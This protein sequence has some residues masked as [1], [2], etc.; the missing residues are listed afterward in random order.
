MS[1]PRMSF[2]KDSIPLIQ[3]T[4]LKWSHVMNLKQHFLNKLRAK[5][6]MM[7]GFLEGN[8]AGTLVLI[9]CPLVFCG[10]SVSWNP[11]STLV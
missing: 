9:W 6:W 10:G 2:G 5:V 4:F 8:G 1:L 7:E 3:L 11:T